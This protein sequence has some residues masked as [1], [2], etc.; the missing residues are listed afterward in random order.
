MTVL[1]EVSLGPANDE[2]LGRQRTCSINGGILEAPA[3][4][5]MSSVKGGTARGETKLAGAA[6]QSGGD[7]LFRAAPPFSPVVVHHRLEKPTRSRDKE[8]TE[9]Q[10]YEESINDEL[11]KTE[12]KTVTPKNEEEAEKGEHAVIVRFDSAYF[13]NNVGSDVLRSLRE[14]AETLRAKRRKNLSPALREIPK[15]QRVHRR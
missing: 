6:T 15:Y 3:L 10:A 11:G 7:A 4:D 5:E 13:A 1:A 12:R 2:G 8:G 9:V 14:R